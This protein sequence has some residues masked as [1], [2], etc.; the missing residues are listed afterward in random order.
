MEDFE[1][2]GRR[3]FLSRISLLSV[4]V[5][6]GEAFGLYLLEAMASGVPVFQPALGAFPEI[7]KLSGGGETYEPND[8]YTLAEKWA[9]MIRD[10]KKLTELSQAA[11]ISIENQFNIHTQASL[12]VE[13]YQTL[14]KNNAKHA[15]IH[16]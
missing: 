6:K 5:R 7:I 13:V 1:G 4:P 3:D 11:R 10:K 8:P 16:S 2:E 15:A 9:E 14:A 12:L